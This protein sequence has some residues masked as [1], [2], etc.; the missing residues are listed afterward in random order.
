LVN[1]VIGKFSRNKAEMPNLAK[2]FRNN[3]LMEKLSVV[4]PNEEALNS[5][6]NRSRMEDDLAIATR[7]GSGSQTQPRQQTR[8]DMSDRRARISDLNPMKIV[9]RVLDNVDEQVQRQRDQVKFRNMGDVLFDQGPQNINRN[10][11]QLDALQRMIDEQERLR[12]YGQ[13]AGSRSGILGVD[14]D[15]RESF[16]SLLF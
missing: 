16:I 8:E 9:D 15:T 11:D 12:R 13:G 7:V 14:P 1:A 5:F 6:L 3:E 10:L 4:F 2:E